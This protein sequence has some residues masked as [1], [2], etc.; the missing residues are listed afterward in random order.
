MAKRYPENLQDETLYMEEDELDTIKA[1]LAYTLMKATPLEEED[2][3]T[4][5]FGEGKKILWN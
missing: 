3:Y 4:Y 2:I 5:V 1:F